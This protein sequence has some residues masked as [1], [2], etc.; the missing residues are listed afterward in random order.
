[1]RETRNNW[2]S[3]LNF[4]RFLRREPS[5]SGPRKTRLGCPVFIVKA[6]Y[7][8]L[9]VNPVSPGRLAG[10]CSFKAAMSF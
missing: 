6:S 7:G 1:M 2:L 4:M 10:A 3:L 9:L 5:A 8:V